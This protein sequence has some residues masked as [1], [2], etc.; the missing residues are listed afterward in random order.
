MK[1]ESLYEIDISS[2]NYKLF[3]RDYIYIDILIKEYFNWN[4]NN[5][6]IIIIIITFSLYF[7]SLNHS[8]NWFVISKGSLM[9]VR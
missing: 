6:L 7:G 1:H 3:T 5:K 2:S 8:N 9:N 4:W